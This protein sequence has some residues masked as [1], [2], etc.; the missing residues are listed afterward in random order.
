MIGRQVVEVGIASLSDVGATTMDV[1]RRTREIVRYA[2]LADELGLDVFGLGEHHGEDFAV[3][4]PAVV[5][6]AVAQGTRRIRLAS[7]TTVLTTLDP[8]RVHEDFATLDLLSQGRAEIVVG[9][10]A[11]P[12]PFALFGVD[13]ADYDEVFAEKLD[14]LLRLREQPR[15]TWNGRHRPALQDAAVVPRPHQE[16][17]PVWLGVGGSPASLER[18]GRLGLPMMLGLIGG[19]IERA[20]AAVELYRSAGERAGHDPSVLKVGLATH[21]LVTTDRASALAAYPNYRSFLAPKRPGAPGF[22]VDQATF[23]AGMSPSGVLMI[24]STEA[25]AEKALRMRD[26]LGADRIL[27]L[28]D[29][30]GLAPGRVEDSI[31]RFAQHVAPTLR[32]DSL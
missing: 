7:A 5:L 32:K 22:I 15:I 26:L 4:S 8:V 21:L 25:V 2:V 28:A 19:T 10:S 3:S 9:R 23:E 30:G 31:A 24:G 16:Q 14:L 27:S 1:G 18:A 13:L 29:W 20:R 6:A 11:Y 17:L 12:D